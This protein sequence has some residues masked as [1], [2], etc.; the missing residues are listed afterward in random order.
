[1]L[2]TFFMS[3]GW[4]SSCSDMPDEPHTPDIVDSEAVQVMFTI[5]LGDNQLLASRAT[6][7]DG[8]YNAGSGLEN[9]ID[10]PNADYR[11]YLFGKDNV[12]VCPLDDVKTLKVDDSGAHSYAVL[13]MVENGNT[14]ANDAL[15]TGCRLVFLANWKTYPEVVPDKTTIADLCAA[16]AAVLGYDDSRA[17][18]SADNLVPMYGVKEFLDGVP[19]FKAGNKRCDI[20]KLHLLRAYAKIEVNAHFVDF[21]PSSKAKLVS[22][23]LTRAN[24]L[25][26]KAPANVVAEKDYVTGSWF[27]DYT[28]INI[29]AEASA[30]QVDLR[31]VAENSFIGYVPEYQNLDASGQPLDVDSRARLEVTFESD[32]A[33]VTRYVDFAYDVTP[34][35]NIA[36]GTHFDI[37][38]NNWYRFDIEISSHDIDWK[39][40]IQPYALAELNPN[41]GLERDREGNIIVRDQT[42]KI[43]KVITI[44]N[45]VIG[46]ED[47]SIAGVGSGYCL[48]YNGKVLCRFFDD[49]R[50]QKFADD[51]SWDLTDANG[52][53]SA[54]FIPDTPG[55]K[56][57]ALSKFDPYEVLVE[58]WSGATLNDNLFTITGGNKDIRYEG[59][60]DDSK[61]VYYL[62]GGLW[63]HKVHVEVV[64]HFD[65]SV[66][67]VY[68]STAT[69]KFR[70]VEQTG[71]VRKDYDL[72][73]NKFE[74]TL[75]A[76][77]VYI[78]DVLTYRVF[79]DKSFQYLYADGSFDTY[80]AEG[81]RTS[82]YVSNDINYAGAS[83]YTRYDKWKH[84]IER[85]KNATPDADKM[86]VT[87]SDADKN[88]KY[89]LLPEPENPLDAYMEISYK[90]GSS[91]KATYYINMLGNI[92]SAP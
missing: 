75:K 68:N 17:A 1:M 3:L 74:D 26:F 80:N 38:R 67:R 62:E 7:T 82:S 77:A 34:P 2:A 72:Y 14:A 40:D 83:T 64:R 39:V 63:Q 50:L 6:P 33:K 32:G 48:K 16:D 23:R 90:E 70:Q 15:A 8:E 57:G 69:Q 59:S 42:G 85:W 44:D 55:G 19:D 81:L 13:A 54:S 21:A 86:N 61:E 29:P 35:A 87:R 45:R 41:F 76:K 46:S 60:L 91:W 51:G 12:L 5:N 30:L 37:A 43:V 24:D 10:I 84:A 78:D 18:L 89:R 79:N 66:A 52:I 9:Y 28:H 53:I 4:L 11:C 25:A 73:G 36:P 27:T 92:V 47:F 56:V 71:L 22:A 31:Q 58:R 20:G 49:G 65:G 88:I